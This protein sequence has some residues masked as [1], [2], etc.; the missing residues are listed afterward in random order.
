MNVLC[1]V[2]GGGI[3]RC[4]GHRRGGRPGSAGGGRSGRAWPV[5]SAC[6]PG[7]RCR[8]ARRPSR[9][10]RGGVSPTRRSPP[11]CAPRAPL[12]TSEG[13]RQAKWQTMQSPGTPPSS[14]HLVDERQI[15]KKRRNEKRE[16]RK[17][18]QKK[19]RKKKIGVVRKSASFTWLY[20][21]WDK[22]AK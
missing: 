7:S 1:V 8:S 16:K 17:T 3:Y 9:C 15:E 5:R 13:K 18:N 19:R 11:S 14:G 20:S 6:G 4:D 10:R 12:S 22:G 2:V 21:C